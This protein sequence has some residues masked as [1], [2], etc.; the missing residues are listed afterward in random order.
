MPVLE[1]TPSLTDQRGSFTAALYTAGTTV[2]ACLSDGTH[3]D[4]A[5]AYNQTQ[6]DGTF[7]RPGRDQLQLSSNSGGGL[8]GFTGASVNGPLPSQ[9]QNLLNTPRYQNDPSLLA[10][11]KT[12]FRAMLVGGVESNAFGMAGSDVSAVT[13]GFADGVTVYATVQ[14]GWYF[15]WWPSLDYPSSVL[16]TTTDGTVSSPM[17]PTGANQRP[18]CTFGADSCVWAGVGMP[19]HPHTKQPKRA[20][21]TGTTLAG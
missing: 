5:V 1:G 7:A 14:N 21:R 8:Q 4:T 3:D 6:L 2:Y 10:R 15:A 13:F 12:A 11:T 20:R 19:P 9:W 18:G 16:V 17:M